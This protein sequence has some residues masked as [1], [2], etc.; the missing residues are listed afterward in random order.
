MKTLELS[1]RQI[2]SG[3]RPLVIAEIGINHEGSVTKAKKMVDD[4]VEAGCECVKFQCHII[5]DEMVPNEVVPG[6]SKETIWQIMA[7]C[8]F[9]KEQELELFEYTVNKGIIYL[10][11]PFSRKAANRLEEMGVDGYKIGSGECNN[12]PLIEHIAS[13]RKPV[14]LS[15]GMN[16]IKDIT[17]A[18]GILE[19]SGVDFALMHCTSMYPTPYDKVRLGALEELQAK[20]PERPIG[21]SDHSM[22]NYPC[23]AAVAKGALLVERH[24]TSDKSWSGPDI[25][26]SMDPSELKELIVGCDIIHQCLGG[27]KDVLPEEQPTIDFAYASVVSIKAINR[28]ELLTEDNIWVKRPGKGGIPAKQYPELLG[29]KANCAIAKDVQLNR[30]WVS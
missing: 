9:T 24:F 22:S 29:R 23:L 18:A 8:A 25:A 28:G 20:F 17:L 4:A 11:T 10:S 27:K 14:I 26:I 13:F 19:K 2:G 21:L 15:T 30:S 6:N 1:G 3:C 12:F 5:D 7:R 16:G